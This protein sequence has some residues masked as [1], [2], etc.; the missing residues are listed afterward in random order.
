MHITIQF[1]ILKCIIH[2]V[3]QASPLSTSR[4]FSS[5]PKKPSCPLGLTRCFPFP[6]PPATTNPSVAMNLP[7]PHIADEWNPPV[8]WPF[9]PGVFH[10]AW[11]FP[12]LS[13][14]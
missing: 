4:I 13:M 2:K 9:A 11:C 3:V 14:L 5:P 10:L 6:Q 1:T 12:G 8:C 7:V